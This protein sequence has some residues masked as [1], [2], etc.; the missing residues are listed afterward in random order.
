VVLVVIGV[1]ATIAFGR[2]IAK[3]LGLGRELGMLSAGATAICGVSAAMALSAVMPRNENSERNLILTVVG[4]TSLSTVTMVI[5]PAIVTALGLSDSEAGIFLGGTIHDV[6]Q[7]VGAGY[8]ISSET[9]EA[10]TVVKLMRVGLLVPAVLVFSFVFRQS[11]AAGS[12][13]RPPLLPS[14]LV[15]FVVLVILNSTG[16]IPTAVADAMSDISRWCLVTAIAALGVKTSLQK[17]A[18]AGWKPVALMV[19]ETLFLAILV[20]SAILMFG[21]SF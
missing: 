6:A 9:G 19:G 4:V 13:A 16:V 18:V 7:V 8:M 5:Y 17:L 3:P 15:A 20:L 11:R 12:S 1:A 2:I 10:A 14:F 21:F